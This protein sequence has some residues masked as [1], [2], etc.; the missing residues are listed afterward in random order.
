MS[1]S[2]VVQPYESL[3]PHHLLKFSTKT[4]ITAF[5]MFWTRCVLLQQNLTQHYK[6]TLLVAFI[7]I[8]VNKNIKCF[9]W[10]GFPYAD[11]RAV[12]AHSA[13][14]KTSVTGS[15]MSNYSTLL[16]KLKPSPQLSRLWT[17]CTS[18]QRANAWFLHLQVQ[19]EFLY[20]LIALLLIS[21]GFT[22]SIISISIYTVILK[23][24]FSLDG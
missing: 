17:L 4:Q 18:Q 5:T 10:S 14:G 2:Q 16:P 23:L 15:N 8:A 3:N 11:R 6:S 19:P 7:V 9:C 22:N 20:W 13:E 12:Q 24:L 21:I 1:Y